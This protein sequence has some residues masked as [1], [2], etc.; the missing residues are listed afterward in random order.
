ME[1]NKVVRCSIEL[2][3]WR[4]YECSISSA[5][6]WST[7]KR[8]ILSLA[9]S[10][11]S[12][13]NCQED[14]SGTFAHA[15]SRMELKRSRTSAQ[16]YNSHLPMF[17]DFMLQISFRSWSLSTQFL[18]FSISCLQSFGFKENIKDWIGKPL[19]NCFQE[20]TYNFWKSFSE[21]SI[22]FHSLY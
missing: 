10:G 15:A 17:Q 19:F 22:D 13:A 3:K 20:S 12:Q 11:K 6:N 9:F 14:W 5:V 2:Y 21:L 1:I 4:E 16:W 8:S 7:A 18:S